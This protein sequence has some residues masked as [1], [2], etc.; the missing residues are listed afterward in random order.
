MV[1]EVKPRRFLGRTS[2]FENKKT[3]S[4]HKKALKAYLK[5][6]RFFQDGTNPDGSPCMYKTPIQDRV[7]N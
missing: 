1:I 7:L 3:R 5:G 2:N 6:K 4:H